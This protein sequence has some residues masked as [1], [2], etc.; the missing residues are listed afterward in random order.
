MSIYYSAMLAQ[1][2][3]VTGDRAVRGLPRDVARWTYGGF[4][5]GVALFAV[6]LGRAYTGRIWE[7]RIRRAELLEA[8]SLIP[9][10]LP[11]HEP[12]KRDS[13]SLF[14]SVLVVL[15]RG[16]RCGSHVFWRRGTMS[17]GFQKPEKAETHGP[18][19]P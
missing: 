4:F 11:R 5:V 18:A 16:C 17:R 9:S 3:V 8:C 19:P 10:P 15:P 12:G 14:Y 7:L 6:L 13:P 2:L 1:V